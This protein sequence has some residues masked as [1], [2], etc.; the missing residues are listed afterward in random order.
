MQERTLINGECRTCNLA[1]CLSCGMRLKQEPEGPEDAE[2]LQCMECKP[3]AL[4][5]DGKC[6]MCQL[7]NCVKCGVRKTREEEQVADEDGRTPMEKLYCDQCSEE[8]FRVNGKCAMCDMEQC[9]SCVVR[10]RQVSG[11]LPT[12]ELPEDPPPVDEDAP[13]PA[14]EDSSEDED[15]PADEDAAEPQADNGMG[16]AEGDA[17]PAW[18]LGEA[19]AAKKAAFRTQKAPAKVNRSH[20]V[21]VDAASYA[22]DSRAL[23]DEASALLTE[24]SQDHRVTAGVQVVVTD[25]RMQSRRLLKT[26]PDE[27]PTE[28]ATG[29]DEPS[30]GTSEGDDDQDPVERPD[31]TP[32]PAPLP[33]K[34]PNTD[35][36]DD[37]DAWDTDAD[38]AAA[39]AAAQGEQSTAAAEA[40]ADKDA[41]DAKANADSKLATPGSVGLP[42][43]IA[44]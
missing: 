30:P 34:G 27:P 43:C 3:P 26:D 19:A 20:K 28:P 29:D 12:E 16:E 7:S 11:P 36:E 23:G 35:A 1:F 10:Q 4:L 6:Q 39:A 42:D 17:P 31:E 32:A 21:V 18:V 5:V 13:P 15:A 37:P 40:L 44:H 24:L 33:M 38:N 2:E 9:G 8:S 41:A 22:A 14:T 25:P